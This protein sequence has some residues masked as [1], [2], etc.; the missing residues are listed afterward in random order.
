MESRSS[1]GSAEFG[2]TS[3]QLSMGRKGNAEEYRRHGSSPIIALLM[4]DLFAAGKVS[5]EPQL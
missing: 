2:A 5:S 1:T 3:A 4:W